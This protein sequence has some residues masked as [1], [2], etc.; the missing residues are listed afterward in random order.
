MIKLISGF[1]QGNSRKSFFMGVEVLRN[2]G[3][4]VIR[5]FH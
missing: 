1:A 5:V 4:V 3:G 2:G